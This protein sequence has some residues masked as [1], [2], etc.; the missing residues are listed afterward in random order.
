MNLQTTLEAVTPSRPAT[1]LW[2]QWLG[3]LLARWAQRAR[4][5]RA[6]R[7]AIQV[8]ATLGCGSAVHDLGAVAD[9]LRR[10]ASKPFWRA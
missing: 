7:Q 10:E 9:E 8:N 2:P 3:A 4:A 5:R 1:E 6:L